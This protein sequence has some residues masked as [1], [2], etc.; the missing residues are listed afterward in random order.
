MLEPMKI[1]QVRAEPVGVRARGGA[2]PDGGLE[3]EGRGRVADP[4]GVVDVVGPQR[5]D[6]LLGAVVGLVGHAAAGE[7]AGG[8]VGPGLLHPIGDQVECLV[9]AGALEAALAAAPHERVRDPPHLAQLGG[10][11]LDEAGG[12]VQLGGVERRSGVQAQQPQ[13]D[14]AQVGALDG[15]VVEA[16]G[17][18]GA[19]VAAGLVEDPPGVAGAIAVRPP[20]LD[21]LHVVVGPLLAEAERLQR[22]PQ[23]RVEV[24]PEPHPGGKLPERRWVYTAGSITRSMRLYAFASSADMK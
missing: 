12:V 4:G 6:R 17:A 10:G 22:R 21:D 20:R 14:V 24:L 5:A 7:E 16:L 1:D 3:P 18:Q 15:P 11:A 23:V 13:A 19:A 8:A 2:D 9:P